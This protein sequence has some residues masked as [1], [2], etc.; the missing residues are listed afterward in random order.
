M[1]A[2]IDLAINSLHKQ[3]GVSREVILRRLLDRGSV[4]NSFYQAKIIEWNEEYEKYRQEKSGGGNYYATN[5]TYLGDK[6]INTA[7]SRYYQG[8][9]SLEQLADFLN[10]K[11]KSIP[12]LEPKIVGQS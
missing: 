10:V 4:S 8:R 12:G 7:F 5:S 11:V 6:Y 1:Y 2:D 9:C 3:Y